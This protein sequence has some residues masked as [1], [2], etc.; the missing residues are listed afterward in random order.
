MLSTLKSVLSG[1]S[2]TAL[3][4]FWE[5]PVHHVFFPLIGF[6]HF[7]AFMYLMAGWHHRL[8]ALESE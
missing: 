4:F 5:I 6:Q 3:A 2:I 1:I 8:D 7:Y